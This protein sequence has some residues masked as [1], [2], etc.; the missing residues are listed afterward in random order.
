M[1]N[2]QWTWSSFLQSVDKK[3]G[4]D[5][6]DLD[7]MQK[8]FITLDEF[9]K[10]FGNQTKIFIDE[11]QIKRVVE[12]VAAKSS[13]EAET[14]ETN[15]RIV[16]GKRTGDIAHW[17][18]KACSALTSD[19]PYKCDGFDDAFKK[20]L[21]NPIKKSHLNNVKRELESMRKEFIDLHKTFS[22]Q[23]ILANN[24]SKTI[25]KDEKKVLNLFAKI[26]EANE[27]A[28]KTVGETLI[29][30]IIRQE[31]SLS[32]HLRYVYKMLLCYNNFRFEWAKILIGIYEKS[33][34]QVRAD[35]FAKA[36]QEIKNSE[37]ESSSK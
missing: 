37:G 9:K 34:A 19:L 6:L 36:E 31:L 33:P 20:W 3:T 17:Y 12:M 26:F 4:S 8:K 15:L 35:A 27:K 22:E 28:V 14:L 29:P 21:K 24:E 32:V 5:K 7:F 23:L 1:H 16:N 10:Q 13:G 2:C 11:G 25:K 18:G 30:K